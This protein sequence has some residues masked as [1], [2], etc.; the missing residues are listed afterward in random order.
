[1]RRLMVGLSLALVLAGCASPATTTSA[2]TT[3]TTPAPTTTRP[4]PDA[5]Q[6]RGRLG[7]GVCDELERGSNSADCDDSP[8][9]TQEVPADW[10]PC[11]QIGAY[12]P[13]DYGTPALAYDPTPGQRWTYLDE[14]EFERRFRAVLEALADRSGWPT[15]RFGTYDHSWPNDPGPGL[16]VGRSSRIPPPGTTRTTPTETAWHANTGARISQPC[17]WRLSPVQQMFRDLYPGRLR[18]R[19]SCRN[20]RCPGTSYCR[21]PSTLRL[22]RL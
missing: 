22:K 6:V 4:A 9:A 16:P 15:T 11:G 19:I 18:C 17:P 20:R 7:D 1:M 2:P 3:A 10:V 21:M 8:N 12:C 5:T 14:L 13:P